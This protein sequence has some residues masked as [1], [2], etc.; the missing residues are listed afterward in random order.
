MASDM[1]QLA[2]MSNKGLQQSS[3]FHIVQIGRPFKNIVIM[4]IYGGDH[5]K[6]EF[7]SSITDP[8][9]K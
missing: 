8:N 2:V 9:W 4:I 7:P 3:T 5:F 6:P 1:G